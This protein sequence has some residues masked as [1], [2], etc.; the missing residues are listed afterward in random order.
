MGVR[1]FRLVLIWSVRGVIPLLPLACLA[2]SGTSQ[3]TFQMT[4]GVEMLKLSQPDAM[5]TAALN[6][7]LRNSAGTPLEQVALVTL[8]AS[9]GNLLLQA[10]AKSGRTEFGHLRSGAYTLQVFVPGYQAFQET[11]QLKGG[12]ISNL[13]I[14]LLPGSGFGPAGTSP[15][16][17]LLVLSPKNQKLVAKIQEAFRDHQ[18]EDAREWLEKLYRAAPGN[19]EV[20]YLYGLYESVV[21]DW[22]KAQSYWRMAVQIDPKH[23]AALIQLGQAALHE[24][25][26]ADAV[27]YLNLAI[28]A[29]PTVWRPH[30]LLAQALLSARKKPP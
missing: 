28:E 25:K 10:N 15:L 5:Q 9:T 20:N 23:F 22:S 24:Q 13:T 1:G 26:P 14:P 21:D 27:T 4:T 30:A 11:L 29:E 7:S 6:V 12:T 16:S 19:P 18:L 3:P 8:S 2:Q 17:G